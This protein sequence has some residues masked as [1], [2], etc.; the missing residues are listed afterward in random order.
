MKRKAYIS[1]LII[2]AVLLAALSFG[3]LSAFA[4]G[5]V[6]IN[7]TN[8]PDQ[9]FRNYISAFDTDSSGSLS[10]SERASVTQ[11]KVNKRG[12]TSLV[13]IEHFTNITVLECE[14][15]ALTSLDMSYLAA[16]KLNSW[17]SNEQVREISVTGTAL[18]M[19][20]YGDVSKMKGLTGGTLSG[21]ILT[22][23]AG[24]TQINYDYQTGYE[25]FGMTVT[26][27]I[28]NANSIPISETNFPDT[29]FRSYITENFDGD[30]DGYLSPLEISKIKTVDLKQTALTDLTGIQY[31]SG[32][33]KLVASDTQLSVLDLSANPL[34]E[35]INASGCKLT[36]L[37]LSANFK[38]INVNLSNQ[39]G[40]VDVALG[41]IE[42]TALGDI[43]KMTNITGV[44][45]SGGVYTVVGGASSISYDYS[46]GFGTYKMPVTLT[47]KETMLEGVA[48]DDINF[49]DPVFRAYVATLDTNGIPGLSSDEIAAVTSMNLDKAPETVN[50]EKIKTLKGIEHFTELVTLT[51]QYNALVEIDLSA[52]TK[53]TSFTCTG[54]SVK[55]FVLGDKLDF[56]NIVS[57]ITKVT[58]VS[59]T[60]P[61][62][63]SGIVSVSAAL[64]QFV[65]NYETGLTDINLTVTLLLEFILPIDE[66]TFPD[67]SFRAFI[68]ENFNTDGLEG[69][70]EAEMLAVEFIDVS[71]EGILSLEG[72]EIFKNLNKL[73]CYSNDLTE[74]DL[75]KN[76]KL[77]IVKCY[78]NDI[79]TLNLTGLE[80]LEEL[81]CYNNEL[82]SLDLSDNINLL[83]IDADDNDLVYL[84]LS[85]NTKLESVSAAYNC[86]T[87]LNIDGLTD[88]YSLYIYGQEYFHEFSTSK[89]LDLTT[90]AGGEFDPSKVISIS[91]ATIE[92]NILT[93]TDP[94]IDIEYIYECAEG[95]DKNF[96]IE[97]PK[98][99]ISGFD[100]IIDEAIFPKAA[101]N[102]S[103]YRDPYVLAE[104]LREY[105]LRLT[106][107]DWN[108][109]DGESSPG[110]YTEMH[111]S[112]C[113]Y[114]NGTYYIELYLEPMPGYEFD[115]YADES[116]FKL[117]G[118]EAYRISSIYYDYMYIVFE[119]GVINTL[120]TS[121]APIEGFEL[122]LPESE[123]AA[124]KTFGLVRRD[125]DALVKMTEGTNVAYSGWYDWYD[126]YDNSYMDAKYYSYYETFYPNSSYYLVIYL[127]AKSGYHFDT[128]YI[129]NYKLNGAAPVDYYIYGDVGM[130]ELFYEYP[131]T[132]A[133][134]PSGTVRPIQSFDMTVPQEII[135]TPYAG[136][137]IYIDIFEL[138]KCINSL[139][140]LLSD[141]YWYTK[142]GKYIGS[143]TDPYLTFDE[144]CELLICFELLVSEYDKYFS[145]Q[146][147]N[148]YKLNGKTPYDYSISSSGMSEY[149]ELMYEVGSTGSY[150]EHDF[151]IWKSNAIS[152]YKICSVCGFTDTESIGE[153]SGGSAT[154]NTLAKCSVCG[155]E[156]GEFDLT[157]HLFDQYV[158]TK[159]QHRL[160]C[161]VCDAEKPESREEHAY[162][163]D[164]VCDACGWTKSETQ[165]PTDPPVDETPEDEPPAETNNGGLPSAAVVGI[166]VG[167]VVA[168][169]AGA[170]AIFWFLIKKKKFADIGSIFK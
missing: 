90:L 1:I 54:N 49:P 164:S 44:T 80:A 70:S 148:A 142:D 14:E 24:V 61:I 10:E 55:A 40:A 104:I 165:T 37:D 73:Y 146:Y 100:I 72:I 71:D 86:L 84:D 163:D 33:K 116:G 111:A 46:V 112:T 88:L 170:F 53:L 121:T 18:D 96:T 25:G 28:S 152:H 16:N 169:E 147:V 69:L 128:G 132:A 21:S 131:D 113:F 27:V 39:T 58:P 62:P 110:W 81:Y 124:P 52:N 15:N 43:S 97:T 134:I 8:F 48:V 32:L 161:S 94:N 129:D 137:G 117:G 31:F 149:V 119:Y 109:G 145:E 76:K 141:C 89:T 12:I 155:S 115:Y 51:C 35:D 153:H 95:Y 83:E 123:F 122:T 82:T 114:L 22:L 50:S 156:Y 130:I 140:Y 168:V 126:V 30:D 19:S 17:L 118:K 144:D 56:T 135:G 120:P 103:V 85:N 99:L 45:E 6:V 78:R 13:G 63:S 133:Y 5:D 79:T 92:G 23:N 68:E 87:Y 125:E 107:A 29:V 138:D 7:E 2:I 47:V 38:L 11:I 67:A 160:E 66:A 127:T 106:Y 36:S 91:N 3:G 150:H 166:T 75:S 77:T 26:L 74:L 136:G 60:D 59:V 9:T 64:Q 105:N 151:S 157:K 65:Y 41:V 98:K 34:L 154:C 162:G 158:S 159:D 42:L 102:E 139:G 108:I 4:S 93:V 101:A 143:V 20:E 167:G 57:D